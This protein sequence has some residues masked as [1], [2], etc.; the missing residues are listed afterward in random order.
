VS[1]ASTV[2]VPLPGPA[3]YD[4]VVGPGLLP[5]AG[6][7]IREVT[8]AVRIAL[9]SDSTVGRLFG[10]DVRDSLDAAGFDVHEML[11]DP[12]E[13]SK[14]WRVAGDLLEALAAAG[15]DRRDAVVALGGG[16]V[17]DLAGF[18]AATYMRGIDF[19]QIPTTL[20]AQVD[21]SVG[22]KTGVDLAA[23]KNL[24]GAFKQPLLVLADTD[25]LASLPLAEWQSGLAEIAKGAMLDGESFLGWLEEHASALAT[26]ADAAS[27]DEAVCKA[28]AFKAGVVAADERER[29]LR[30][31]LNYGHTL[32]HAIENV[33]GYG[34]VPHGVAVAE[35]IRFAAHLALDALGAPDALAK[36]QGD[37]LDA[38]GIPR[39]T[40]DLDT[41]RLRRAMSSDKKAHGG[42]PRFVLLSAPGVWQ[43]VAVDEELLE[44]H[45]LAFV[46][47]ARRR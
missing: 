45:L 38:L 24:A 11:V 42:H 7:R 35:G 4:V 5:L 13:A 22:G 21:S 6:G 9:V 47:D 20:L 2:R 37:V 30:E 44:R 8:K 32:G 10:Q 23:G 40:G 41:A 33:A 17:G 39:V 46:S 18:V 15:L 28:V 1:A 43:A 26:P 19:V 29:D 31:C 16:V 14:S 3:A 25:V 34:V 12:G 27:V 36:R